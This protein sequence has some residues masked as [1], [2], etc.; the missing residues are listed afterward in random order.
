[1][2]LKPTL[3]LDNGRIPLGLCFA[4]AFMWLLVWFACQNHQDTL[5]VKNK[6]EEAKNRLVDPTRFHQKILLF[7]PK[8]N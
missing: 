4:W 8:S 5:V 3:T 6:I 1:M 2:V 7:T